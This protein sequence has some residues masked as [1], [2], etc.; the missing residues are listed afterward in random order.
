MPAGCQ[1]GS[2]T[3]SGSACAAGRSGKS[4]LIPS[5]GTVPRLRGNASSSL[6]GA[7]AKLG[8]DVSIGDLHEQERRERGAVLLA[9][10][11]LVRVRELTAVVMV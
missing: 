5:W 11:R 7:L 10:G 3:S 6:N 1:R 8:T 4:R 2:G 9:R